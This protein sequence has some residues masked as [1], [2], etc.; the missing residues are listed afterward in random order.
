MFRSF[1]LNKRWALWAW[2][3]VVLILA[4]VWY[5][6]QVSVQ[7]NDWY[8]GFYDYLQKILSKPGSTTLTEFYG[9][10]QSVQKA[11]AQISKLLLQARDRTKSEGERLLLLD[12]A[13]AIETQR[14]QEQIALA[15]LKYQQALLNHQ[16][17]LRNKLDEQETEKAL[18]QAEASRILLQKESIDLQEKISVRRNA[19][20]DGFAEKQKAMLE[21]QAKAQE[22]ADKAAL[23]YERRL[24][25]LR[26][27]NI[28]DEAERKEVIILNN[29]KRALED[30]FINGQLTTELQKELLIARDN[31]LIELEEQLE[32]Q[33]EQRQKDKEAKALQDEEARLQLE[34]ETQKLAANAV[35]ASAEEKEQRLYEL[36]R[37]GLQNRLALI[38]A[39][40]KSESL[41]AKKVANEI[42]AL[43]QGHEQKRKELAE[44][45]ILTQQDLSQKKLALIAQGTGA[46]IEAL[47]QD[48]QARKKNAAAIKAL[49]TAEVLVLSSKEI[50][51]I[52]AN[53]NI[54]ALNAIIPGWGPAFATALTAA[55]VA[56]TAFQISKINGVNFFEHGGVIS[57]S[58]GVLTDG[59]RHS[60]GGIKLV[61][62][63]NGRLLGEV[64][65]GEALHV[66]S[67]QTV[68]NNRPIIDA[69]LDTSM[70][71]NGA[72]ITGRRGI[73]ENGGVVPVGTRN[74]E[75]GA[76]AEVTAQA[77]A[78][79]LEEMRG[80]RQAVEAFPTRI[81]AVVTYEQMK[82]VADEASQI[83]QEAAA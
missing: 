49:A 72:P 25:D 78:A 3:G 26:I 37:V 14:L 75:G 20:L 68:E 53:A 70:F 23:E 81:R 45:S 55:S 71:R 50:S 41:E 1:F 2:P 28:E 74:G 61:D 64:E 46:I 29:Y 65:R 42:T 15:D 82:A 58:G 73:Y 51:G 52:W 43:D 59:Q 18:A 56:R 31:A 19:L 48:E 44:K 66:Y 32:A 7:I 79:L 80:V 8:G 21:A 57:P 63:K 38:R 67:R 36:T 47:G 11:E 62:G 4:A 10:R 34:L 27:Q 24:T 5:Q 35:V 16:N 54:N 40:G 30:A 12:K 9:F 17:T 39:A 6:V 33:R 13:S 60:S 77:S 22:A 76:T 69:L 83:E